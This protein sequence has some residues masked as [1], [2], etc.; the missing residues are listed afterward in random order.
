MLMFIHWSGGLQKR[1]FPV[2]GRIL[3][4][5]SVLLRTMAANA[6]AAGTDNG[7]WR[8]LIAVLVARLKEAVAHG[9]QRL[10]LLLP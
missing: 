5:M 9:G 6:S 1:R 3:I 10:W 4:L 2:E 8:K 7:Q